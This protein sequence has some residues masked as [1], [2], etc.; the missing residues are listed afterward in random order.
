M[1]NAKSV[2]LVGTFEDRQTDVSN[3]NVVCFRVFNFIVFKTMESF[4]LMPFLLRP[5]Y[6]I[7]H[8][9]HVLSCALTI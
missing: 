1:V 6:V 3:L 8:I 7:S 2:M 4:C 5:I 9:N